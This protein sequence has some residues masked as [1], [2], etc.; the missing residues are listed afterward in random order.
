MRCLLAEYVVDD[1]LPFSALVPES[2]VSLK[3]VEYMIE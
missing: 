3:D 1:K 2:R